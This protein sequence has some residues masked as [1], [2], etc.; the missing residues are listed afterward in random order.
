MKPLIVAHLDPL[1]QI[2]EARPGC[3]CHDAAVCPDEATVTV[4]A[5]EL[6]RLGELLTDTD[7][8][9]RG[10]NGVAERLA[11][12]YAHRGHPHPAFAATNLTDAVCFTAAG[13]RR[14]HETGSHHVGGDQ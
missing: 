5:A 7:V 6:A 4:N 14:G 9:L 3:P 13:L 10:G 12:F 1:D 11:D 8:F 2:T